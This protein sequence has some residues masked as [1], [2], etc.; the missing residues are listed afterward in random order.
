VLDALRE[1]GLLNEKGARGV[2]WPQKPAS[3][4]NGQASRV[5]HAPFTRDSP[6]S[7]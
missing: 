2:F 4:R 7:W 6:T 3:T 1:E 5:R